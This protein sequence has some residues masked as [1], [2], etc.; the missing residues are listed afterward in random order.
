MEATFGLMQ[1]PRPSSFIIKEN[2]KTYV[3]TLVKERLEASI[4]TV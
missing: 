2:L 1:N 3:L 4:A